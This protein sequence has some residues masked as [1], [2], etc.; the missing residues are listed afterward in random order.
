MYTHCFVAMRCCCIWESAIC[1]GPAIWWAADGMLMTVRQRGH[2]AKLVP[3]GS[4][5]F[6]RQQTHV[7]VICP[8]GVTVVHNGQRTE[9]APNGYANVTR[10]PAHVSC[11]CPGR[12]CISGVNR[13]R[14][15]KKNKRRASSTARCEERRNVET[16]VGDCG[17]PGKCAEVQRQV[18]QAFRAAIC[19]TK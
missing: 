4:A 14:E 11:P 15:Y 10:H 12:C 13:R 2:I 1:C 5:R 16:V 9:G 7:M 18:S 17:E 3:S 19:T 8:T 6:V